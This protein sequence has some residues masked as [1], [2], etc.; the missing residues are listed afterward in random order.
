[1]HLFQLSCIYFKKDMNMIKEA[2]AKQSPMKI[3]QE[4]HTGQAIIPPTLRVT[5]I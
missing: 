3:M 1:M 4:N 2:F 5:S